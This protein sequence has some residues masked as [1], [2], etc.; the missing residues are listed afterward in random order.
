MHPFRDYPKW[1]INFQSQKNQISRY[2]SQFKTNAARVKNGQEY[3]SNKPMSEIRSVGKRQ[4]SGRYFGTQIFVF[5]K[6]Y[7]RQIVESA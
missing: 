2:N 5:K 1:E 3:D 7:A 6:K 4:T